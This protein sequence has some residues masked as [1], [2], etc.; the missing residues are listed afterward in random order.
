MIQLS[1][2]YVPW[3]QPPYREI[4]ALFAAA[5]VAPAADG[6]EDKF[7]R[8]NHD[9]AALNRQLQAYVNTEL[10]VKQRIFLDTYLAN[11]FDEYAACITAGYSESEARRVA[12]SLLKQKPL[13]QALELTLRYLSEKTAVRF[14]RLVDEVRELAFSNIGDFVTE[15]GEGRE[16]ME[17]D[18]PRMRAVKKYIREPT[19]YGYKTTFELHDKLGAI[20]QLHA[21]I[22]PPV[23]PA[24]TKSGDTLVNIHTVNII[25]VP[26]GQFLPAPDRS[27]LPKLVTGGRMIDVTPISSPAHQAGALPRTE[28]AAPVTVGN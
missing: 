9:I 24:A 4:A 21:M 10:T 18:H 2:P 8:D 17:W 28:A 12:K 6:S 11:G 27:A 15:V 13:Q 23:D 3:T 16:E 19:R 25:P 22:Q 1:K 20:K 7:I 5:P 14:S 26:Q